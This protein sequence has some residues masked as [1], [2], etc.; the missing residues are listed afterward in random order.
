MLVKMPAILSKSF[1]ASR[2]TL[3]LLS[4]VAVAS[5]VF[6]GI[7]YWKKKRLSP[8]SISAASA[9]NKGLLILYCTQ[10]GQSKVSTLSLGA[11]SDTPRLHGVYAD[12][13]LSGRL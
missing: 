1:K 9:V 8:I 13:W 2:S 12:I 10:K 4:G 7:K 6:V 3:Y 5:L 11:V